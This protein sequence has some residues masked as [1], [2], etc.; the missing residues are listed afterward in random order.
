MILRPPR[1]TRTYTLLP[2]TTLFLSAPAAHP[3]DLDAGSAALVVGEGDA[4]GRLVLTGH[5]ASDPE[6]RSEEHTSELHSLT[7]I[8]YAVFCLTK[9]N[10]HTLLS[11]NSTH[12]T[13][14]LQIHS[15]TP[16][17]QHPLC[18]TQPT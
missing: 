1:S 17:R 13:H 11:S 18:H 4:P 2:Y 6:D 15:L 16:T 9:T 10:T 8:T 14:L 12:I 5:S 3:D 7:R